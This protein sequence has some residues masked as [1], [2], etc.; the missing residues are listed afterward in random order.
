MMNLRAKLIPPIAEDL[1]EKRS[2]LFFQVE[3]HGA[4]LILMFDCKT[5]VVW[6]GSCK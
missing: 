4:L 1:I 6:A 5:S 3:F 2:F